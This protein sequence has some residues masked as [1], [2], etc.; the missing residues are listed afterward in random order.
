MKYS[1]IFNYLNCSAACLV[2]SNLEIT[3]DAVV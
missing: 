1:E 3:V 2:I